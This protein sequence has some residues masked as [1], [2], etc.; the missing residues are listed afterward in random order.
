MCPLIFYLDRSNF[1]SEVLILGYTLRMPTV[2]AGASWWQELEEATAH[3]THA[4][5]RKQGELIAGAQPTF[6]FYSMQIPSPWAGYPKFGVGY[7]SSVHSYLEV[8]KQTYPE[9]ISIVI[10]NL[11][12]IIIKID[13]HNCTV[14]P[15]NTQNITSNY[16]IS[17]LALTAHG[18]LIIQNV[19][20]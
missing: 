9:V 17:L 13:H 4:A 16:N 14:C 12:K 15:L 6:S 18:P 8:H 19:F 5:V 7:P 2:K 3:I 20:F 10:L 1:R 11:I